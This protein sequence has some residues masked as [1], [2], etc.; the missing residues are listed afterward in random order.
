[1]WREAAWE[2]LR[3]SRSGAQSGDELS[4][5][6]NS[7]DSLALSFESDDLPYERRAIQV[8]TL[9]LRFS[10]RANVRKVERR[11]IKEHVD[12]KKKKKKAASRSRD[13]TCQ[14]LPRKLLN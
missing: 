2:L 11:L 4:L 3:G 12:D 13:L 8:R 9:I 1:M 14:F 5:A 7:H 6:G 10:A